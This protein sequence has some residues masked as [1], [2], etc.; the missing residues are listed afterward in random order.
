VYHEWVVAFREFK[1][2]YISAKQSQRGM[3]GEVRR[4]LAKSLGIPRQHHHIDVQIE[5]VVGE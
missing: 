4:F 5:L 1:S 3:P 2:N